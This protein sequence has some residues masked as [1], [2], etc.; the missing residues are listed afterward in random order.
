MIHWGTSCDREK[1]LLR[2]RVADLEQRLAVA[3]AQHVEQF[4]ADI[5]KFGVELLSIAEL[6][7]RNAILEQRVIDLESARDSNNMKFD[8]IKSKEVVGNNKQVKE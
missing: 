8:A 4:H 5:L 7:Q 1:Y 2:G 6:K 3:L